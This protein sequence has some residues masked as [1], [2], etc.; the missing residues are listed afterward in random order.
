[1]SLILLG[2]RSPPGRKSEDLLMLQCAFRASGVRPK[3][4]IRV[5][6]YKSGGLCRETLGPP[7]F[8]LKCE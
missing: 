8:L 7:Y 1:M 5:L 3:T 6:L 4:R 2:R